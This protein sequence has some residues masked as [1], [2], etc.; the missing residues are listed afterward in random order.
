MEIG[1][2]VGDITDLL[3]DIHQSFIGGEEIEACGDLNLKLMMLLSWSKI[4]V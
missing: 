4:K 2:R 1:G 3:H